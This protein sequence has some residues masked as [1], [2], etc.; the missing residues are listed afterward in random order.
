MVGQHL[1]RGLAELPFQHLGDAPMQDRAP[2]CAKVGLHHLTDHIVR[3]A[4]GL[5]ILHQ[6]ACPA[7]C[8]KRG[9]H[10]SLRLVRHALEEGR[11]HHAAHHRRCTHH[12]LRRLGQG[13]DTLAD[14]VRQ[15]PGHHVLCPPVLDARA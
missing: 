10:H 7:G 12:L 15:I 11:L 6:E 3:E 8:V 9:Q 2:R 13:G 5:V 4:M 1:D 14:A